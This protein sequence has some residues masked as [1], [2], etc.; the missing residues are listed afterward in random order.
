MRYARRKDTTHTPIARALIAHGFSVAD[1]SALGGNFPDLVIGKFGVDAKIEC[2]SPKKI[3]K[4]KG[5]GLSEGQKDFKDLWKGAPV[6]VATCL[7]DV[8]FN[9]NLLLKRSHWSK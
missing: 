6:I 4:Q 7:E 2:K 3:H 8:L 5:D 9:F 1:T